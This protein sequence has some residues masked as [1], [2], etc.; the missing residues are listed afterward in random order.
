M[1]AHDVLLLDGTTPTSA[2]PADAPCPD[3]EDCP[4]GK[5]NGEEDTVLISP[6][7]SAQSEDRDEE[8]VS[9]ST[10]CQPLTTEETSFLPSPSSEAEDTTKETPPSS[11]PPK[12]R[13][14]RRR[15]LLFGGSTDW[16][17]TVRATQD[18]TIV[19][20]PS[21]HHHPDDDDDRKQ[22]KISK[23]R[24][25]HY[26]PHLEHLSITSRK[27]DFLNSLRRAKC[28][29][30]LTLNSVTNLPFKFF[31][32]LPMTGCLQ[33]LSLC[34][35]SLRSQEQDKRHNSVLDLAVCLEQMTP[36][37]QLKL[38]GNPLGR[39]G[40][41]V[42]LKH[43]LLKNLESVT[44]WACSLGD[45][46]AELIGQALIRPESKVKTLI[47][48]QNDIKE[49]GAR[50]LARALETNTTLENLHLYC[51][52]LG[53]TGVE[54]LFQ[55]LTRNPNCRLQ[56]ISLCANQITSFGV[57]KFAPYLKYPRLKNLK[58]LFLSHNVV[59]NSGALALSEALAFRGCKLEELAL[60]AN[61]IGNEGAKHFASSMRTNQSLSSLQLDS[62]PCLNKEGANAF[63]EVFPHS[64]KTLTELKLLEYNHYKA[65]HYL[66]LNKM[67]W[68]DLGT[69]EKT[70]SS[71]LLPKILYKFRDEPDY[72]QLVLTSRP[73]LLMQK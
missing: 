42:L 29:K 37:K 34:W 73:E 28:L 10:T 51:N 60:R 66:R 16:P 61:S 44:L 40:I 5:E 64:N 27:V 4:D 35:N 26:L 14:A 63:L 39:D 53:D 3:C 22:K 36:L 8:A 20:Y 24:I 45:E 67:G 49:Q 30:T 11:P 43:G 18:T 55:A 19:V 38:S 54:L 72:L 32:K 41:Q 12:P 46:G 25:K 15:W 13:R 57:K 59:T 17:V 1:I 21:P 9:S 6:A 48:D 50:A 69:A 70:L 68:K 7:S 33:E 2:L 56:E 65:N 31:T 23:R 62:N 71:A 47:L 58:R 52:H